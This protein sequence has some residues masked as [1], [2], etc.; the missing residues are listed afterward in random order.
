MRMPWGKNRA[1]LCK[2]QGVCYTWQG[3]MRT[4]GKASLTG[5]PARRYLDTT[6]T[7]PIMNRTEQNRTEQNRTEQNRTEQNRTEQNRT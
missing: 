7:E 6:G 1:P 2:G 3:R 5:A 4:A